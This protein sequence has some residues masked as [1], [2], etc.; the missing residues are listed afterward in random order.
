MGKPFTTET[1]RHRGI[2]FIENPRMKRQKF[3]RLSLLPCLLS[4]VKKDLSLTLCL[5]VS[6][7]KGFLGRDMRRE[8]QPC[9]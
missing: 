1:Q 9:S 5:C 3:L 4:L 2:R 8:G 6:V 7:V